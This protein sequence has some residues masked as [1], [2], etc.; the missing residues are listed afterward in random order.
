MEERKET[1]GQGVKERT[2]NRDKN[3]IHN[4]DKDEANGGE[5]KTETAMWTSEVDNH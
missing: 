4:R 5:K 2:K 3:K 1:G